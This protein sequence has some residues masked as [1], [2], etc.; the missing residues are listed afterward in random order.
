MV[1]LQYKDLDSAVEVFMNQDDK[2]H[3]YI[4]ILKQ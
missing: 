4:L 1:L 3:L 2:L